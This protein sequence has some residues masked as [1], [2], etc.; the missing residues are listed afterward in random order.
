MRNVRILFP[1]SFATIVFFALT[2]A[3]A[4]SAGF[5]LFQTG[6]GASVDLTGAGSE[7]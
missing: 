1:I 4:Q 3:A 2:P 5:D 6:S 7:S